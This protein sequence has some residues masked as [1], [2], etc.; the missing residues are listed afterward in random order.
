MYLPAIVGHVPGDM[1]RCL[2]AFLDFCYFVRHDFI[3]TDTLD[4]ITNAL[5][6]FHQY[7]K[8]FIKT[9][10]RVD[11]ISLLWQHSLLHYHRSIIL[12][13]SPNGL[14]SSITESKHI[15][16]VKKPWCR[17]SRYHTLQQMLVTNVCQDKLTAV[18]SVFSQKGM[19]QGTTVERNHS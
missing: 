3:C 2:T 12:F 1:V 10:V 13:R 11:A 8:V 4:L 18:Q 7:H 5:D 19:M 17:S 15:K 16:A 6:C 14:S 9:G